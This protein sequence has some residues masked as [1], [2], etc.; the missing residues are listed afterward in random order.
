L[1][2]NHRNLR[3]KIP[4]AAS[5][6]LNFGVLKYVDVYFGR[7]LQTFPGN[8]CLNIHYINSTMAGRVSQASGT[9]LLNAKHHFPAEKNSLLLFMKWKE[10]GLLEHLVLCLRVTHFNCLK[11]LPLRYEILYEIGAIRKHLTTNISNL[12]IKSFSQHTF[13]CLV[14]IP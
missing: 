5:T 10:F 1:N 8:H 11:I 7:D 9:S 12:Y 14:T 13:I 4:K 3:F 6:L 2:V